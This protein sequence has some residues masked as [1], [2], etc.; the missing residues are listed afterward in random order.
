M[1]TVSH[2]IFARLYRRMHAREDALGVTDQRRELLSGLAGKV[3]EV[4]CGDGA[5][6]SLY[7]TT[8]TEVT[9]VEPESYLRSY[10]Q[11]A[12]KSAAAPVR[13]VDGTA[14][15]LP[16]ADGSTDAAVA[17]LV[18]CSV[19]DPQQAVAEMVR[20]LRP[21]GTV[22]FLE[23][24]LADDP[25]LARAQHRFAPLHAWIAGGCR[26]DRP[27]VDTLRQAGLSIEKLRPFD[28]LLSPVT[29]L[30]R[31]HVIGVARKPTG[32]PRP[33]KSA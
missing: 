6:F 1:S 3:V 23:H 11:R 29:R 30:S 32:V 17:S 13:V 25:H 4:G 15:S 12:A 21:G 20:V 33:E 26:P 18:L 10:A 9:A 16:L 14:D 27:T 7:P 8:V 19:T 31:P 5:N 22:H 2:P 28:F 24:V